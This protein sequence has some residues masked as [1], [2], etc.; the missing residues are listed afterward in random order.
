MQYPIGMT[1]QQ[2]VELVTDYLEDA[3]PDEERARFELHLDSCAPCA[4]YLAQI[5]R[6][7]ALAGRLQEDSIDPLVRDTLLHAFRTWRGGAD[8]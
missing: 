4:E 3:L 6:T 7:V 5:R 2:L 1:C 8:P